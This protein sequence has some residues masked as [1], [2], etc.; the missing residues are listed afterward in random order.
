MTK[1]LAIIQPWLKLAVMFTVRRYS[2]LSANTPSTFFSRRE[3]DKIISYFHAFYCL[4]CLFHLSPQS[5]WHKTGLQTQSSYNLLSKTI[6]PWWGSG[7]FP[8]SAVQSGSWS[9][10]ND[11]KS[12]CPEDS[13]SPRH[14]PAKKYIVRNGK[15]WLWS[16]LINQL[17]FFN[18]FEFLFLSFISKNRLKDLLGVNFQGPLN[19]RYCSYA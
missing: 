14:K 2:V 17:V 18:C 16:S 19:L 4:P 12:R 15:I 5:L 13:H 9:G 1:R 7:N 3:I 8:V 10:S 11:S 6:Q